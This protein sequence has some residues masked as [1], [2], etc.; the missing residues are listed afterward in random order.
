MSSATV[1]SH[2]AAWIGEA[3][4]P[5]E[6]VDAQLDRLRA[7]PHAG[8]LPV[9]NSAEGRQLR[10]WATQVVVTRHLLE[11]EAAARGLDASQHVQE[12]A[13]DRQFEAIV[14]DRAAA[15]E[16]GGIVANVLAHSV[17]AQMVCAD[18]TR[19]VQASAVDVADYYDRNRDEFVDQAGGQQPL[20]AVTDDIARNLSASLRRRC[21]LDWLDRR[22]AALVRLEPGHE[23][24]GDPQQPDA[25]HRH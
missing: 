3:P 2:T 5:A 9:A 16:L 13:P 8:L 11:L 7:G 20:D 12:F 19:S 22:R 24:P 4:V 14:P 15:L 10:R 21:F 18:I 1:Q 6:D 23:H 17:P 25:T